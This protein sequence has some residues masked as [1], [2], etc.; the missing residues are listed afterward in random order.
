MV[1]AAA[2]ASQG[3]LVEMGPFCS[4]TSEGA[5]Y[6]GRYALGVPVGCG[7]GPAPCGPSKGTY[8]EAVSAQTRYPKAASSVRFLRNRMRPSRAERT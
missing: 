5:R 3:S 8:G 4:V 1:S 6:G 7:V 2:G